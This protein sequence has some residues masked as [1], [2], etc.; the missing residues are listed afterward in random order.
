[1]ELNDLDD[2]VPRST[3]PLE[4][5]TNADT[6]TDTKN[7]VLFTVNGTDYTLES[8][9]KLDINE[10]LELNSDT[11][12][13]EQLGEYFDAIITI[14]VGYEVVYTRFTADNR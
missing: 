7:N 1:M 4:T 3:S 10:L 14:T 8:L 12:H 6:R 2:E 5:T 11:I 13:V 9:A